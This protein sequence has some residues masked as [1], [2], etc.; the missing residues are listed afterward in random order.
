[1]GRTRFEIFEGIIVRFPACDKWVILTIL[2]QVYSDVCMVDMNYGACFA[3][4]NSFVLYI[5]VYES[6]LL[7]QNQME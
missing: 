7:F 3:S 6:H 5:H 4:L 2:Q 1:M